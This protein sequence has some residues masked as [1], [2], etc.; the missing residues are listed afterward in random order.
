MDEENAKEWGTYS[1]YPQE[2][3]HDFIQTYV[4][5]YGKG[6]KECIDLGC[7]SGGLLREAIEHY[8]CNAIGVD[9]SEK[10]INRCLED[11]SLQKPNVQFIR[12]DIMAL[13][14]KKEFK[15][16]FDLI[17]SHSVLHI[18]KGDTPTKFKLLKEIS[19]PN[20]IIFIDAT[21]RTLWNAVLYATGGFLYRLKVMGL[22]YKFLGPILL[23]HR[24]KAYLKEL[25]KAD[26]MKYYKSANYIDLSYFNSEEF[27]SSF[28]LLRLDVVP[29]DT[30][31]TG[32][33]ARFTVRRL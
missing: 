16:R 30:I 3:Y 1:N 17:I 27:R 24:P 25:G 7:G 23:P 31:F 26:Y 28:E 22:V 15:E 33:K 20:A 9:V 18:P 21:P 29:Q 2:F 8:K 5:P 32:R 4:A 13:G 10:S 11:K 19:K 14:N 12:E 6:F